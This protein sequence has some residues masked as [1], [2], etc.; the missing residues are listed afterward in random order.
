MTIPSYTDCGWTKETVFCAATASF[1]NG[2]TS[3][4]FGSTDGTAI[5]NGDMIFVQTNTSFGYWEAYYIQSGGGSTSKTLNRAFNSTTGNYSF[6]YCLDPRPIGSLTGIKR[7]LENKVDEIGIPGNS[8]APS[9]F[10]STMGFDLSGV[11]LK[12]SFSGFVEDTLENVCSYMR[13]NDVALDSSR[14]SRTSDFVW[15]FA[16]SFSAVPRGYPVILEKWDYS[17][18]V[19]NY[20]I[21]SNVR[22]NFTLSCI[23]RMASQ[24]G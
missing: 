15:T 5:Q 9:R 21:G 10:T 7:S 22:V 11:S 24:Y 16:D 1:T 6:Y 23:G 3:A 18:D 13:N 14:Y 20:K 12:I 4:T 19:S 17:Y 8:G 2:S